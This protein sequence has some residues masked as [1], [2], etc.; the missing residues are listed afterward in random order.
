M[1][2][3]DLILL[4]V[5]DDEHDT[6]FLK[7]A[8]DK[9][10]MLVLVREVRD[11]AEALDYLAGRGAFADRAKNPVPSLVLLDV[12]LPKKSGFEVLEWMR[13]QPEYR[14]TPA[15]MLTSSQSAADVSRAYELGA[16][17]YHVKPAGFDGLL[18]LVRGIH[19]YW[20]TLSRRPEPRGDVGKGARRRA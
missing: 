7:R 13:S 18:E 2:V 4:L 19:L 20:G 15:V 11:G 16:N 14:R 3:P 10:G 5:E 17:A 12:K 6:L 8:M 1:T 9:V